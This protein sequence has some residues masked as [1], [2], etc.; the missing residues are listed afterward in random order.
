MVSFILP[1]EVFTLKRDSL[2]TYLSSPSRSLRFLQLS[3]SPTR[4]SLAESTRESEREGRRKVNVKT[5]SVSGIRVFTIIA[6][7]ELCFGVTFT[8]LI[9]FLYS[10]FE[11]KQVGRESTE[12]HFIVLYE[13]KILVVPSFRF[14]LH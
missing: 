5:V 12:K 11:A 2:S 8:L 14:Y 7:C 13:L 4:K 3:L 6:F 1:Y 10:I 9:A